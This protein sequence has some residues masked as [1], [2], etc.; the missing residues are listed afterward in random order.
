MAGENNFENNNEWRGVFHGNKLKVE[1]D[2]VIRPNNE[3]CCNEAALHR[4]E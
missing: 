4:N 3:P 2:D 1:A